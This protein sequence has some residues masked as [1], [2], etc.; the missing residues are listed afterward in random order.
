MLT[1]LSYDL[2]L[3]P[4]V[5]DPALEPAPQRHNIRYHIASLGIGSLY[6]FV[7]PYGL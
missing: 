7:L 6:V 3:A 1:E 2:Q 4:Q 5:V